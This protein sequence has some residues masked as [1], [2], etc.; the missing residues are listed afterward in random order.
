VFAGLSGDWNKYSTEFTAP[1]DTDHGRVRIEVHG[2]GVFWLDSAS[3]MPADNLRG[4]RADVVAAMKPLNVP[5]VRYPGG[6]FADTYHWKDGIGDRDRR[7]ERWS[8]IWDEWEPN[9]FGIDEFMDLARE[10]GFD[11]QITLNYLT[12]TAREAAEWVQYAN[13]AA[14]SPMGRRRASDGHAPNR[15]ASS[16]GPSA[17]KS[18]NS[19]R[20]STSAGTM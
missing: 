8:P 20:T 7:P 16:C 1:E 6:C 15:T 19:A 17:T 2:A 10:L 18:S 9:D 11:V 14:E 4:M 13:G 5:I 3:L 12:G